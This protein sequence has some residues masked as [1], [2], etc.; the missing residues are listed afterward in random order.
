MGRLIVLCFFFLFFYVFQVHPKSS[1]DLALHEE[2]K[3]Q[4]SANVFYNKSSEHLKLLTLAK[5]DLQRFSMFLDLNE[6]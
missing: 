5:G 2:E 6:Q 4:P 1:G 3:V